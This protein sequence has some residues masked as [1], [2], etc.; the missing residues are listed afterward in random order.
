[1][2]EKFKAKLRAKFKAAAKRDDA[3]G[4]SL[5]YGDRTV[6]HRG[7]VTIPK[8]Q[9]T[10][11]FDQITGKVKKASKKRAHEILGSKL[12]G[13]AIETHKGLTGLRHPA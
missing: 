3:D 9:R 6:G 13:K 11:F 4:R 10:A 2:A 5:G 8:S 1:M 7:G 12:K